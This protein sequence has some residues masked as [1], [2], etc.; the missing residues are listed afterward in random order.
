MIYSPLD[1]VASQGARQVTARWLFYGYFEN[2]F[3]E[4]CNGTAAQR[5]GVA[6]VSASL[7]KDKKYSR[8]C[9]EILCQFMN[10]PDKD[11]LNE[12]RSIIRNNNLFHYLT[13]IL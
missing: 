1:E 8:K 12:L 11:V 6:D 4:C 13:L 7:L 5:R 9:Q 2:E 3:I 10:D